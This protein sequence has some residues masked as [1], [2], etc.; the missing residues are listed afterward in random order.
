MGHIKEPEGID[1]FVDSKSLTEKDK[2]E[3]SEII[4]HYKLTGRK[5]KITAPTRRVI[6]KKNSSVR[7]KI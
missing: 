1:F 4:A 6:S 2:R 7:E 5:K 3:I